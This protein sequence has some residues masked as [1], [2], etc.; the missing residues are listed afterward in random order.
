MKILLMSFAFA[1]TSPAAWAQADT[2]ITFADLDGTVIQAT[3]VREQTLL[4]GN[5]QISN[6]RQSDWRIIIGPG[7]RIEYKLDAISHT[8][9]GPRKA[10]PIHTVLRLEQPREAAQLGGGHMVWVFEDQ[11]LTNLRVYKG[12]AFKRTFAF[13]RSGNG[14]SCSAT[15]TLARET[16]VKGVELESSVDD[17]PI[18]ILSAKQTSSTCKVSKRN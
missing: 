1:I 9:A 11:T 3:I 16:G 12:G 14:L 15:E 10:K 17:A 4:R 5:R 7:D 18:V 13:A 8:K 6:S 2:R